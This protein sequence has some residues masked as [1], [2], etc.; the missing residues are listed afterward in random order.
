MKV[1]VGAVLIFAAAWVMVRLQTGGDS[2]IGEKQEIPDPDP[3][4]GRI[5]GDS[6]KTG[7]R[8]EINAGPDNGTSDNGGLK[9]RNGG[10]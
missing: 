8:C 6:V 1:I 4:K 3:G 10:K 9:N 7:G 2:D 5:Y